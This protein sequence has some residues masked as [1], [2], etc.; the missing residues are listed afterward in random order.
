MTDEKIK[1]PH[2]KELLIPILKE[3]RHEHSALKEIRNNVAKKSGIT[4]KER[5]IAAPPG[6]KNSFDANFDV[7]LGFL[8]KC[9]LV[10]QERV[11]RPS[12]PS[13]THAVVTLTS[14]GRDGLESKALPQLPKALQERNL[15]N[16]VSKRSR[17][18]K[19]ISGRAIRVGTA[20]ARSKPANILGAERTILEGIPKSELE[21]LFSLWMQNVRRLGDPSQS[22]KHS[23]AQRIVEAVEKEWNRRLPHIRLNPD[24]FTWPSTDAAKG[25][26]GFDIGDAPDVGM[27]AYLE[28]RVGRTQGQPLGVRRA[29]LDRV[30]EGTLPLYGGLD[31]YEAW[32][33]AGSAAR[34]QKLA[35]AI[36]AFTRNAK[37]RNSNRL[38]DA[39][40]E[41]E[42][43]LEY[44]YR[45]YYLP[46]FA[47][48]WPGT[49]L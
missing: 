33:E 4:S 36:A 20:S 17:K 46:R 22:F 5:Q 40:A 19:Q 10:T 43:D 21:R 13:K 32:G 7:A 28:Y 18:N 44:L 15:A 26:G 48:G 12:R 25:Y 14:D 47:F 23:A 45:K 6:S 41:W 2:F 30:V 38:S 42:E 37:R 35:E 11:P 3:I 16:E 31:Y 8:R 39:I 24:H 34:L 27:L 1:I 29:I 49:G 9:G